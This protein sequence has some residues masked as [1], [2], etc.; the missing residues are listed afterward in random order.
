MT[1]SL[2]NAV[3]RISALAVALTL[4]VGT[5]WALA[6]AAMPNLNSPAMFVIWF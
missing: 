1:N 5:P 3:P 4:A 2:S 6:A